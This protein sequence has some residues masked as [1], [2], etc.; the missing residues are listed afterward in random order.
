MCAFDS[1]HVKLY[2]IPRCVRYFHWFGLLR[3]SIWWRRQRCNSMFI[4]ADRT[5]CNRIGLFVRY[6]F[7]MCVCV[8]AHARAS[9]AAL[10]LQDIHFYSLTLLFLAIFDRRSRLLIFFLRVSPFIYL[11]VV[12]AAAALIVTFGR[13]SRSSSSSSSSTSV[14]MFIVFIYLHNELFC[15]IF[16]PS[17]MRI[18][19]VFERVKQP[20]VK[21]PSYYRLLKPFSTCTRNTHIY[22]IPN[23]NRKR[24]RILFSSEEWGSQRRTHKHIHKRRN[25]RKITHF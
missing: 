14:V 20:W 4:V 24:N 2:F 1:Q 8:C 22:N 23:E 18:G 17:W 15:G 13:C 5:I 6:L 12:V 10:R 25:K 9:R 3:M 16:L 7:D 11:V 21:C 19:C